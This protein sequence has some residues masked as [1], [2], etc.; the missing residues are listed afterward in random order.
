MVELKNG[1][2]LFLPC[3]SLFVIWFLDAINFIMI[4]SSVSVIRKISSYLPFISTKQEQ[5]QKLNKSKMNMFFLTPISII[6]KG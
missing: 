5:L 2:E 1:S 6:Y 3:K 4:H